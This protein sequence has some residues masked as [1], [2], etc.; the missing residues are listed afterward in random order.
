[1]AVMLPICE[2]DFC[3]FIISNVLG[4]LI[5]QSHVIVNVFIK[6]PVLFHKPRFLF[7]GLIY[8][9]IKLDWNYVQWL[10]A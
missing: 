5:N 4:K 6:K 1:M 7:I 3:L 2:Y 8:G 10:G 9:G